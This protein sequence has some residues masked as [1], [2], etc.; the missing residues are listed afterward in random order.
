ML[1]DPNKIKIT[2]KHMKLGFCVFGEPS[3]EIKEWSSYWK[4]T[5]ETVSNINEKGDIVNPYTNYYL[6]VGIKPSTVF[7]KHVQYE[8]VDGFSPNLNKHLHLGHLSNLILAKAY[9]SMNIGEK[10]FAILGDTL[11]GTVEKAEALEKFKHYCNLIDYK[12]DKIFY[13][14]EQVLQDQSMLQDG[15]GDYEG[16]KVFSIGDKFEVGIKSSL[17]GYKTTYT[18]Q[19]ISLAQKLDASTL[20]LTGLEQDNH[21]KNLK[22]LF[23]DIHHIGLGLVTVKGSKMSSSLGNVIMASE[24]LAILMEYF[25]NDNNLVWNVLAGQI[26]K[27]SPSSIKKIDMDAIQDFKQSFG[28]YISYTQ[29]RMWSAGIDHSYTTE[30]HSDLLDFKSL[31]AKYSLQPNILFEELVEHCK[32]INSLYDTHT[33]KNN[34]HNTVMFQ[35]LT[36]DLM[37][38]CSELGLFKVNKI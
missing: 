25:K 32:K 1:L 16:T 3:D 7:K 21:F 14:S 34:P 31:K 29:V 18:Y 6:P 27:S 17:H 8:Y 22:I 35:K 28:L 37:L 30:Y 2:P 5:Q 20:Y 24:V 36:D 23:P 11:E 19:D 4:M 26:L 15:V 12:V 38:A 33:I 9:Q 10:F 13:A